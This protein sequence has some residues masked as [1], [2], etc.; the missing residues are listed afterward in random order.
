MWVGTLAVRLE[1][2][3]A[4]ESMIIGL[5]PWPWNLDDFWLSLFVEMQPQLRGD[6]LLKNYEQQ[7]LWLGGMFESRQQLVTLI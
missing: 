2:F 6:L 3:G 4:L 5:E 1:G 7:R